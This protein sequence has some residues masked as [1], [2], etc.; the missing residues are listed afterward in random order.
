MEREQAKVLMTNTNVVYPGAATTRA[1]ITDGVATAAMRLSTDTVLQC[2]VQLRARGAGDYDSGLYGGVMQ[3]QHEGDL[4]TSD[5]TMQQ[6]SNFARVRRLEYAEIGIWQ[7]VHWVRGNFLPYFVGVP[8]VDTAT[9][10][11]NKPQV[12]IADAGGSLT[13]GGTNGQIFVTMVAREV[14]SDYERRFNAISAAYTLGSGVTTGSLTVTTP[15][16]SNYVYDTYITTIGTANTTSF[17]KVK[18]RTPAA[19][20]FV[21]TSPAAGTEEIL[22]PANI[23]ANGVSIFPGWVIGRDAF[24]RV[25]LNGMSLQSYITPAG[26]SHSDPLAQSRKLGTKAMFKSVIQDQNYL[27][28]FETSSKYPTYLAA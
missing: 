27:V 16:S 26:A 4:L 14:S 17:F 2:T 11:T 24:A 5:T 13:R 10:T 3:P 9:A 1:T 28:R 25:K 22:A 15:S 12:A 19:T 18:S 20:T 23:P 21:I 8:A 6:A 7:G